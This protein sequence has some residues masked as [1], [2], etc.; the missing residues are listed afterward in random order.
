MRVL[1]CLVVSSLLGLSACPSK[2]VEIAPEPASERSGPPRGDRL[3]AMVIGEWEGVAEDGTDTKEDV[4]LTLS[5]DGSYSLE[6]GMLNMNTAWRVMDDTIV[7][8]QDPDDMVA[9]G[10]ICFRASLVT[11]ARIEGQ[12]TYSNESGCGADWHR[13]EL[14]RY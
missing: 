13:V 3:R 4:S 9:P 5:D 1:G 7:L 11:E 12:W 6:A 14:D 10:G 8:D 2:G